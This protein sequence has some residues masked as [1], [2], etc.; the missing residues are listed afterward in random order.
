M[1]NKEIYDLHIKSNLCE[2]LKP[3]QIPNE[4]R[5]LL[6]NEFKHHRILKLGISKTPN[7]KT[8]YNY[9]ISQNELAELAGEIIIKYP[10]M[11]IELILYAL[12]QINSKLSLLFSNDNFKY[13]SINGKLKKDVLD[14]SETHKFFLNIKDSIYNKDV[15]INYLDNPSLIEEVLIKIKEN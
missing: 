8:A 10:N 4:K 15:W 14:I 11:E 13:L 6:I 7:S 12:N 2:P 1:N 9:K 5:T 3:E